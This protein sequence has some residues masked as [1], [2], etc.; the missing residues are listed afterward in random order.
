MVA[1][2]HSAGSMLV[3][4][5]AASCRPVRWQVLSQPAGPLEWH[6]VLGSYFIPSSALKQTSGLWNAPV[7]VPGRKCEQAWHGPRGCSNTGKE[8]NPVVL[9][10]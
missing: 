9:A 8:S 1:I 5:E 4:T 2:L 3:Y 6:C 7:L 10:D